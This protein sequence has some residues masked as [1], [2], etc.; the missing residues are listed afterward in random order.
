MDFVLGGRKIGA[1][2]PVYIVAEL[3]ANHGQ[4]LDRA[5]EL[6]RIAKQTG[7]DAVKIQTY[8]PDTI[9]INA[10]Q[11]WFRIGGGTV[12][13][14]KTLFDLYQEAYT[15][16]EWHGP[17]KA[18]AE[19]AGLDFFS[20]PFDGSAVDFLEDLGVPVYKIA[21]FE[22]VD[23]PLIRKVAASGK[24]LIMST[25]M[26]T[27]EEISEAVVTARSAGASQI[28]LLKCNSGYPAPPGE[29]NL[30]TIPHLAQCF[31][32]PVGLSDHTLGVV[33]PVMAVAL[34]AC[35]IEK[36]L[37]LSRDE[38][39]P[40]SGFSLEPQE[41]TSMVEAVRE[42][43]KMRGTVSYAPTAKE[44]ASRAFRRSLFI[45]VD[46][47]AGERFTEQNLRSIRPGNG[48]HTRFYN[49]ALGARATC[50]LERGTPLAWEHLIHGGGV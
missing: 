11:P 31:D 29:M 32:V 23:L 18:E 7:A 33:A 46:M 2:Q 27:L 14:G 43:E 48:L 34:G 4:S 28:A 17:L 10:K 50:D 36:H 15:P 13:D 5:M 49:L 38:K 1:G 22:L 12:W 39:G 30:L 40:D 6:I 25:G 24:P 42:A 8:T 16:W 26:A 45:V 20:S 44:S 21:S 41:F 37:T 3:S 35:L 9:T 19:H 47:R